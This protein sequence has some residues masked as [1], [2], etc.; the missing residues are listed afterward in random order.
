MKQ[1]CSIAKATETLSHE[2]ARALLVTAQPEIERWTRSRQ[3]RG[4]TDRFEF[5]MGNA[6]YAAAMHRHTSNGN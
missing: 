4:N 3:R 5:R 6:E 1:W 2:G